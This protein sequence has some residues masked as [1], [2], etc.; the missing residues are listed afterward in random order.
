MRSANIRATED[1]ELCHASADLWHGSRVTP[2]ATTSAR[3]R[4]AGFE[5]RVDLLLEAPRDDK[6]CQV[7]IQSC[8]CADVWF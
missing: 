4:A 7:S 3:L 6:D 8:D 2:A 5:G 1:N